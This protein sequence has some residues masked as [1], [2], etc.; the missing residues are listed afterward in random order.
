[1]P[2]KPFPRS[3]LLT[4]LSRNQRHRRELKDARYLATHRKAVL[5]VT[6]ESLQ[7]CGAM[8]W[9]WV[10]ELGFIKPEDFKPHD[11]TPVDFIVCA[12]LDLD[13]DPYYPDNQF[14]DC[15]DCGANLQYRP[16]VPP[17]TKLC[18][19]CAARRA[20]EDKPT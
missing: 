14:T 5:R 7:I 10:G 13:H 18:I 4:G 6:E 17:G 11:G 2:A 16:H 19:C 8:T 3:D 9:F 12:R 1:V 20:R 15:A